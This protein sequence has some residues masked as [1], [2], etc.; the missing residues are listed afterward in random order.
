[1]RTLQ[2]TVL[3]ILFFNLQ[4]FSQMQEGDKDAQKEIA[5][6]AYLVRD[7]EGTGWMMIQDGSKHNF[8]QFEKIQLKLDGTA[9]LIE[10][11]GYTEGKLIHDA[12]AVLTYSK[13]DAHFNLNSFLFSG[14]Q[15]KF[16]A[17]LMGEKLYWYP[18]EYIRYIIYL[19]EKGQWYETGEMKRGESW[20]Q[21]I[22]MTLDKK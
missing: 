22:E 10:G 6:L 20:F 13:E 12:M 3:V 17:E 15:G 1:M 14:R 19:N 21:F 9:L 7:W 11:R 2:L 4:A 5:K 18:N 16:K 8:K